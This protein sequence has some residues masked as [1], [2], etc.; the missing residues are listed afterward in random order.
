MRQNLLQLRRWLW[1]TFATLHLSLNSL[2]GT[3]WSPLFTLFCQFD[4]LHI[5]VNVWGLFYNIYLFLRLLNNSLSYSHR[6][7]LFDLHLFLSM[8]LTSIQL[9]NIWA[10]LTPQL[11]HLQGEHGFFFIS[12]ASIL[13]FFV[14]HIISDFLLVVCSSCII[15]TADLTF[16]GDTIWLLLLSL[17]DLRFRTIDIGLFLSLNC[18]R[19]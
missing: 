5:L 11:A 14:C 6:L 9:F 12:L 19:I 8:I 10:L 15:K 4:C 3:Q 1:S 7:K 16:L 13:L 17:F 2:I 18:S